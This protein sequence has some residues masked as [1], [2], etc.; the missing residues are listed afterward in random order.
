MRFWIDYFSRIFFYFLHNDVF[1]DGFVFVFLILL[2]IVI[3]IVFIIIF[4]VFVILILILIVILIVIIIIIIIF[5]IIQSMRFWIDYF[6]RIFFYF[7]HND[8][9]RD[10][11][12][13]GLK[14]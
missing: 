5:F 6:S 14:I 7:L 10:G 8:V 1:R 2:L 13:F 4:I 3:L 12:V 9:F 11:F